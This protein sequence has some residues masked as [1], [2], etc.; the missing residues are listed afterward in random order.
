VGE[1]TDTSET[2]AG[3]RHSF[4]HVSD[5]DLLKDWGRHL[6]AAWHFKHM[7]YHVGSSRERADWRD[8]DVRIMVPDDT[9]AQLDALLDTRRLNLML[10]LWGQKVT[11]LPIDCQ[12]QSM[13][14]GNG[15][16]HGKPRSALG[17]DWDRHRYE[18][19][20]DRHSTATSTSPAPE[21]RS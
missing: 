9:F 11:G 12:V 3:R 19:W 2:S 4:L 13:S 10:S 14:E 8:V 1:P 18:G 5:Q 21:V 15:D 7:P 16:Y 6:Y 17:L 20:L